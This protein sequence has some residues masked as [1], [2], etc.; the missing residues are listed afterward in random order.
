ME[1]QALEFSAKIKPSGKLSLTY[2]KI[3]MMRKRIPIKAG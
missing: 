2:S 1:K 3:A